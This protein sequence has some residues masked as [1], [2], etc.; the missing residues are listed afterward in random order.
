MFAGLVITVD[1]ALPVP[2]GSTRLARLPLPAILAV[3]A[4]ILLTQLVGV[5]LRPQMKSLAAFPMFPFLVYAFCNWI[6]IAVGYVL[7]RRHGITWLDI[8]F[9]NFRPSDFIYALGATL[10][11]LFAIYPVAMLVAALLGLEEMTGMSYSLTTPINV[12]NAILFPVLLVPLTEDIIFRGFLLSVLCQRIRSLWL[13]GFV[14]VLMFAIIH[15]PYFG[16][17]GAIFLL[18]W[19]PLSVL[20][21]FGRESIY[22]PYVMHVLNN[23]FAY[24][25]VPLLFR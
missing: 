2:L 15:V 22:P 17:T 23:L 1:S 21:F 10:L 24:V 11:E 12:V 8:G 25:A 9:R 6:V 16:W 5:L 19:I 3:F 4:P 14:G 13:V 18:L 7:L 20:L